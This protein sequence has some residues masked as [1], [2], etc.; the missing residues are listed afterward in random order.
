[1]QPRVRPPA[2]RFCLLAIALLAGLSGLAGCAPPPPVV[3]RLELQPVGFDRLEGWQ[4][5]DPSATLV[6]FRRSCSR[7]RTRN[8]GDPMGPDPALGQVG[9]WLPACAA[10]DDHPSPAAAAATRAFFETWFQPYRVSDHGEPVGLFTGY[11]EPVL[12][13]S[14]RPGGPYRV[15]LHAPPADLLRIDLSRFNPEFAG[16]AIWGRVA[17][18]ALVPYYTRAEIDDGALAGRNLELLWVDDP[19]A[20]FFLQIQGSGQIRLDDGEVIRVGYAAQNGQPY[21]AIGRDLIEIGAL[22]RD[23]VSLQTI[24]AWLAAHPTDATTLMERNP[25][26]IFFQEHPELAAEDG[27]LGSEGVPLTAGRSLAVDRR[28]LPLGAPVWLDASAPRPDRP[29][30]EVPLRRLMIAQDTGG[31]I[32]GVVRGDVFWGAGAP[33]EAIA[34]RMRSQGRLALFL[35]R[36]LSPTS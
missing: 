7:L 35:P 10:A 18:G 13:G 25:S 20:K 9:D 17:D 26:Y 21:R 14:R 28:Y 27:P 29:E 31:A 4:A 5:D 24:R 22:S 1:M 6:A 36:A 16:Y 33:A 34:G 3:P 23:Q 12:H 2:G 30:D 15:P 19:I 32:K 11:Y 8:A